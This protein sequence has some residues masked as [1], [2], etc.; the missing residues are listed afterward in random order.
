MRKTVLKSMS[1]LLILFCLL[2]VFVFAGGAAEKGEAVATVSAPLPESA[3]KYPWIFEDNRESI[4]GTVRFWMPFKGEQGMD[5]LIADFNQYYPNVK[6][7]LTTYNNNADGNVGVNTA[8]MAGDVD[9]LASFGLSNAYR[10]WENNLYIPLDAKLKE[11][12]IELVPNWGTDKYKYNNTTFSLPCGGLS[13][14]VVIN[15]TAW[16]EAGLGEIPKEWTWDEY[17]E[18][19]RRMTKRD[20]NGNVVVYGGSNYHSNNYWTYIAYQLYGKNQYYG[21][22]GLTRWDDP[23]MEKALNIRYQADN[24][25]EI[26]YPLSKYRANNVQTQMVYMPG[27]VASAITPNMVRFIRDQENY[28]IG[29]AH[30]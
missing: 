28:Q 17:L 14:Y 21:D 29:R 27:D 5:A 20:A 23:M 24:V 4:K 10:R 19:S 25:E 6:V 13:Y 16:D 26:W 2:P 11:E 18:A 12:G 8:I 3:G 15:K 9:V 22:D 7:E 1:V 30:V